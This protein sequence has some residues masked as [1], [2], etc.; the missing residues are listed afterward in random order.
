LS[1][2]S[3]TLHSQINAAHASSFSFVSCKAV[4]LIIFLSVHISFSFH[5]AIDTHSAEVHIAA[6]L[7][8]SQNTGTA[9]AATG[10]QITSDMS[11]HSYSETYSPQD[12]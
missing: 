12:N 7:N 9:A 6:I 2:Y 8:Q 5:R 3:C 10:A 4:S 11:H 1:K